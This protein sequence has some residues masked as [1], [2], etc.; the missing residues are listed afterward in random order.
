[1][2]LRTLLLGVL[3][4]A[5]LL[6]AEI[7]GPIASPEKDW[8]QWR[9]PRRD[10]ISTETGLLKKWPADGPPVLW[11]AG[12]LGRGWSSPIIVGD[13]LYI[14]G[15]R[16]GEVNVFCL[17][18]NGAVKW[19][20]KN[21]A[22]WTTNYPGSRA[23]CVYSEGVVYHMNAF[24]RV[25]AFDAKTGAE[26]WKLD[27]VLR[28]FESKNINWGLSECLLIDGPRLIVSPGGPKAMLAA[29]DKKS[30]QTVWTSDPI[31]GDSAAYA[32][33]ALYK[34]GERRVLIG[35]TSHH[36][37]G[38][39]ADT[40]KQLWT[41]PVRNNWGATCCAPVVQGNTVFYAAPDGAPGTAYTIDLTA[42]PVATTVLWKTH[43]EP[44]TGAG[45][46]KDGV[47]YTNGCKKSR[48][49][50][51][52][53]WKTGAS[54]YEL[55]IS[56]PTNNHATCGLLWAEDRLYGLFEN[57]IAALLRPTADKFEVDGQFKLADAP[58]SDAWAHPVLL[59][60]RLY[61]RYHETLACYDV[62]E[63]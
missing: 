19:T 55:L 17:D 14:T 24:G 38:I 1:M 58:K 59:N 61:L 21:G 2:N 26:L 8:P 10:G 47:L 63:K 6:A 56:T 20:A 39:D 41:V 9:G 50:H 23:S 60:G 42:N 48:A 12:D 22:A 29:V 51:A 15:D 25:A 7:D 33:P 30:G 11:K 52:L 4:A 27:S 16:A 43:V 36:G 54:K 49:L 32:S 44:L 28:Q 62:K 35:A 13:A 3:F 40:G 18:L 53:D 34:M 31:P 45:I 46:L 57:G 5:N 37:Y